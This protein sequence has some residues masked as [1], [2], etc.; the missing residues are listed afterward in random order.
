[1]HDNQFCNFTE[2]KNVT[3]TGFINLLN[4]LGLPVPEGRHVLV[5]AG[6]VV[7]VQ[8]VTFVAG[9]FIGTQS[10]NAYLEKN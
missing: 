7:H 2:L 8:D 4:C 3:I 6:L 1:M 9:A 10:I 5:D